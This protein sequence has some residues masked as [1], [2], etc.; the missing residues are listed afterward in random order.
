MLLCLSLEI[1]D[2]FV[3]KITPFAE[4]KVSESDIADSNSCK[5]LDLSSVCL[6]HTSYLAISA[7]VKLE[8]NYGIGI[9][10]LR[11]FAHLTN[12]TGLCSPSVDNDGL[13][14]RAQLLV[15]K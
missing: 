2:L 8:F 15:I 12:A 13:T 9:V 1:S 10:P 3:G 6:A 11:V 5:L 7:L 4:R 14:E